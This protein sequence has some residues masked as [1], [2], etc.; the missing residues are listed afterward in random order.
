MESVLA[1]EYW[2]GNAGNSVLAK[3]ALVLTWS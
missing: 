2:E 1:R 3:E